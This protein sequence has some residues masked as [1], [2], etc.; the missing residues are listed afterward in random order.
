MV[1]GD[2]AAG[3]TYGNIGVIDNVNITA[4]TTPEPAT[5]VL[6]AGGMVPLIGLIKRRRRNG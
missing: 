6:V 2:L 3:D 1:G 4:V 5:L